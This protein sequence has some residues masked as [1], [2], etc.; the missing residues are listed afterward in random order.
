MQSSEEVWGSV[1]VC[2]L[3]AAILNGIIAM[4]W[5]LAPAEICVPASC[6]QIVFIGVLVTGFFKLPLD[7]TIP[8]LLPISGMIQAL[9]HCY[10]QVLICGAPH[11]LV[12]IHYCIGCVHLPHVPVR[13]LCVGSGAML[14]VVGAWAGAGLVILR[15]H[16]AHQTTMVTA[17]YLGLSGIELSC[18]VCCLLPLPVYIQAQREDTA[19]SIGSGPLPEYCRTK[20]DN[21]R[22]GE[23]KAIFRRNKYYRHTTRG[24]VGS[25]PNAYF[26]GSVNLGHPFQVGNWPSRLA[27]HIPSLALCGLSTVV[28]AVQFCPSVRL[29]VYSTLSHNA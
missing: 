13:A 26:G 11:V 8:L 4:Q 6:A 24:G 16:G 25:L 2:F 22:G 1:T 5:G 23:W 29:F 10:A 20:H 28:I 15:A 7:V 19:A 21:G 3:L 12:L 9:T 18:Y 27:L 14:Y 17:L